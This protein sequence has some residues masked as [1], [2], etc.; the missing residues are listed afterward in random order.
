[1]LSKKKIYDVSKKNV[2]HSIVSFAKNRK[3]PNFQVLDHIMPKERKI[4]SVVG[5]L[6]TSLGTKLWEPLAKE[7]ASL[8]GFEVKD[9][10]QLE[11]PRR[12]SAELR[13]AYTLI[14]DDRENQRN[15]FTASTSNLGIKKSCK[16]YT[17]KPV[18]IWEKPPKG[19]GIDVWLHKNNIDYIFD[20]KTVHPNVGSYNSFLKQ[21][22]DWYCY[23]YSQWPTKKVEARIVFPYNPYIGDFWDMTINK[24]NPLIKGKEA[25]VADEFWRFCT[26]TKGTYEII[27]K[28]FKDIGK[29]N[30][31]SKELNKLFK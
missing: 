16:L 25:W 27:I 29:E 6:E 24:G 8:N 12:Y 13:K 21:I 9:I 30:L 14:L 10:K 5:G 19:R 15:G 2:I 17:K 28:A 4:R 3:D 31:V 7:L 23:Y 11:K 22:L 26:G 1:M 20:L 18:K